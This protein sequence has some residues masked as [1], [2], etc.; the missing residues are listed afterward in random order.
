MTETQ[1]AIAQLSLLIGR[2]GGPA[3]APEHVLLLQY[4][5]QREKQTSKGR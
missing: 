5:M 1:E 4:F 2:L 3:R